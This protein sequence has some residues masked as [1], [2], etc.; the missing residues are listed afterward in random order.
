[1]YINVLIE[2]KVNKNNMTFTY[3]V[4]TNLDNNLIGKRVLVPF[5]NRIIEG[6]VLE[7]A[8]SLMNMK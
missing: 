5:N 2:T 3:H 7:Y 4:P 8:K 6:F 1:M